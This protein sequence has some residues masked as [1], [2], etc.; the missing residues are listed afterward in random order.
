MGITL[1]LA[2]MEFSSILVCTR[3]GESTRDSEE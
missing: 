3:N 1:D 2:G